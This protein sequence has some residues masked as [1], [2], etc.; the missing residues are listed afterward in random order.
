LAHEVADADGNWAG[1]FGVRFGF[2]LKVAGAERF[3][4]V[5]CAVIAAM[6]GL[7]AAGSGR[8]VRRRRQ[9]ERTGRCL[10]CGYDLR[11]TPGRCPECGVEP[12]AR[13]G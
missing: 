10:F 4:F 7:V 11:A 2:G 9:R 13:A 12:E 6:S 8:Y 5:P 1:Q 3:V